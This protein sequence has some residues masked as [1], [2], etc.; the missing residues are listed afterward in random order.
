[1]TSRTALRHLVLAIPLLAAG[2]AACEGCRSSASPAATNPSGQGADPGPPTARL[3]LVSD[4][5]GALE[6][7]G[8]TKDQ[9][10]GLD[11][12]GAWVKHEGARAPA[13]VVA[14]SGPLFFMDDAPAGDRADQDRIKA[15][16]IARV[17]HGLGF[18]SF[19][20]GD[21][22]WID[23]VPAFD[24]RAQD[25]GGTPILADAK[26]VVR[27]VGPL[28]IG[29]VGYGQPAPGEPKPP[30]EDVV[31]RGFE[32][33]KRQGAEAVIALAAV[34]RGEAKRIADAVPDLTAIVVGSAKSRGDSNTTA[35][36]GEQVGSVLIVQGANHLQSVAVLD[37]YVRESLEPGKLVKFADATGLELSRKRAELSERIDD[38]HTKVASWERDPSV[39][40]ADVAAR[41]RELAD[42]ETQREAL[43][44][45]PPPA[46]GSF[47]RYAL[48]E[49]RESLGQDPAVQADLLAYY[50]AVDDHN[51]VAFAD[52][53]P[54]P[55]GPNEASYV[56]IDVCTK[57][58]A[59][60]RAVW[61]DTPHSRAYAT[62]ADQF[63]E[64]NLECVSC[65]VTGYEQPGGSTVTH[66]EKLQNVQCE[67][68]H[69]PGSKHVANPT[70]KTA[71]VA[72]PNPS[73]C[74]GCHHPPHVEGFDPGVKLKEILGPGHG[75]PL[76]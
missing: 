27:D 1:M 37:L 48:K 76:K 41:R 35:P 43:D 52:R 50:K 61:N 72:A 14:S 33:A 21:N 4:L 32:E 26:V 42:L 53:V 70:D 19:A 56:G 38:L 51:R 74:L 2:L 24:K 20:P 69:G 22:D 23:G 8:C 5:A 59:A 28:K 67:V 64:Y 36:Q 17:L 18:A 40:P 11:H 68:C 3:Y 73:L 60:P 16:T 45:R 39:A 71:I 55:A 66:V 12:F 10:G 29:F 54:R 46:K 62:I 57:C 9:L 30:V 58:H 44:A 13:A 63:K 6:P 15:D 75:M 47:F 49:M 34:G 7:C 65:H 25:S 31:R